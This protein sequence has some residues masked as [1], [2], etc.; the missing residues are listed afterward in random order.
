MYNNNSMQSQYDD[1]SWDGSEYSLMRQF[2]HYLPVLIFLI[3]AAAGM[4]GVYTIFGSAA[5]RPKLDA[6]QV[7]ASGFSA[8]IIK[9]VP[10]KPVAQRLAQS[11]SPRRIGIISGHKANDPG[12]VCEDGLTEEAVNL[13]IAN[14]VVDTLRERGLRTDLL[15]EFDSRLLGYTGTAVVSI[16]ADSCDYFNEEAT[17]YKIADSLF[18]DSTALFNCMEESYGTITQLPYHAY[19]I[20]PHMTDYHAFREI[21]PGTPAIIIE[22]GFMNLDRSLLVDQPDIPANAIIDGILC[23]LEIAP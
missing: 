16:H 18:T 15:D 2:W 19:T 20:T 17:G 23:Y 21:A 4:Y 3:V 7:L 8:P 10:L 1:D 14:K 12:A 13:I 22:T 5:D 11:P 6:S 9:A